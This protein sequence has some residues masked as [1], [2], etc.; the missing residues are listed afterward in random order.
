VLG[1]LLWFSVLYSRASER[2]VTARI[3]AD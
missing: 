3:Q 1:G 2:Y